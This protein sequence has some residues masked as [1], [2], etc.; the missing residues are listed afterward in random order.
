[1]EIIVN[2]KR[3]CIPGVMNFVRHLTLPTLKNNFQSK[4]SQIKVKRKEIANSFLILRWISFTFWP[5]TQTFT[6][7]PILLELWRFR[8]RHQPLL[9]SVHC[10]LRWA[11]LFLHWK[12]IFGFLFSLPPTSVRCLPADEDTLIKNAVFLA[13]SIKYSSTKGYLTAVHHT[14]KCKR[15]SLNALISVVTEDMK[16]FL[17]CAEKRLR[18]WSLK[19]LCLQ[20]VCRGIKW[21]Q[22]TNLTRVHL[23]III[24]HLI[25]LFTLLAISYTP[26]YDS[27]R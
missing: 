23:P 8:C 24:K 12:K 27:V 4:V 15:L 19:C 9:K 5:H 18:A 17:L 2:S 25:R 14:E 10:R 21:S 26:N 22:G 11:T 20:L 3:S 16:F 6:P 7:V 1:M 13:R